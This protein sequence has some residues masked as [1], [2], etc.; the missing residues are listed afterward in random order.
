MNDAARAARAAYM[1][2]W[3]SRNRD[4]TRE[5]ADRYWTRRAERDG[6]TGEVVC[7]EKESARTCE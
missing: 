5:Y 1:R 2:E 3:R 4:R 6:F 7:R